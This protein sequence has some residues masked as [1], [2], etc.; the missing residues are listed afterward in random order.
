MKRRGYV[1]NIRED[2]LAEKYRNFTVNWEISVK[3]KA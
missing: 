2:F 1:F 3:Q